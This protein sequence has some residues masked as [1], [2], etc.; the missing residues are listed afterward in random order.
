MRATS[1]RLRIETTADA[2]GEWILRLEVAVY[3]RVRTRVELRYPLPAA[4]DRTA[5]SF[6]AD[7]WRVEDGYVAVERSFAW[8][9]TAALSFRVDGAVPR[10]RLLARPSAV[11]RT[12][13]GG[14]LDPPAVVVDVL[15]GDAPLPPSLRD[16][17]LRD[18]EGE[19]ESPALPEHP[20][21]P[22]WE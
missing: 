3:C 8:G 14:R 15:E 11:V 21:I 1:R 18:G 16:G 6:P 9:E 2:D 12:D 10:E 22:G 19:D 20:P 5:V 4:V 13:P 17:A 7:D